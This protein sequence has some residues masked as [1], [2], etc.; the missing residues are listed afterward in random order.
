MT[1]F[2]AGGL[3]AAGYLIH[4]WAQIGERPSVV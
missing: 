1:N 2:A 3:N 4:Y